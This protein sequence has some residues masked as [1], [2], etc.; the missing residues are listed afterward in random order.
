[1]GLIAVS[2]SLV[3]T[4]T[5]VP[6]CSAV[7]GVAVAE[8]TTVCG[9]VVSFSSTVSA[10]G[11]WNSNLQRLLSKSGREHHGAILP[12]R[13]VGESRGAVAGGGLHSDSGVV[14][15]AKQADLHAGNAL[16][17]RTLHGYF[18]IGRKSCCATQ[19]RG[20]HDAN[21]EHDTPPL[22]AKGVGDS[23]AV[24]CADPSSRRSPGLRVAICI[25]DSG[26]AFPFAQWPCAKDSLTV[27][28]QRGLF[29][30]FPVPPMRNA[31]TLIGKEQ[32]ET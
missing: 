4:P 31:R 6:V 12:V 28:R 20:Q 11:R 10:L 26:G 16:A 32:P 30:R 19:Q 27:A 1:M 13:Q 22:H 23:I 24:A 9:V 17:G 29:T 2:C 7:V 15:G 8:T 25:A 21:D 14:A 18:E 5:E 3:S